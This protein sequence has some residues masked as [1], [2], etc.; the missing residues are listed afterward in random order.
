MQ[1]VKRAVVPLVCI[2]LRGP[3]GWHSPAGPTVAMQEAAPGRSPL[4]GSF[5][6]PRPWALPLLSFLKGVLAAAALRHAAPPAHAKQSY[7]PLSDR[8][9]SRGGDA[10]GRLP[11]STARVDQLRPRREEAAAQVGMLSDCHGR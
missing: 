11:R 1:G 3:L 8:P 4:A 9:A 2:L 7:D 10:A 5:P 6:N